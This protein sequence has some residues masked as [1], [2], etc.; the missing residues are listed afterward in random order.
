MHKLPGWYIIL[1]T[2][3]DFKPV[4]ALYDKLKS[5]SYSTY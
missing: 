1:L 4:L 5:R 3:A 2:I